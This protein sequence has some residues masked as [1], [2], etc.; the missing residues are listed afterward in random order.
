MKLI[1]KKNKCYLPSSFLLSRL[2]GNSTDI[3]SLCE[4]QSR[5]HWNPNLI[6]LFSNNA[7]CFLGLELCILLKLNEIINQRH[8]SSVFLFQYLYRASGMNTVTWKKCHFLQLCD[9]KSSHFVEIRGTSSSCVHPIF[10]KT[11]KLLLRFLYLHKKMELC[12][13]QG[14]VTPF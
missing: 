6:Y 11:Y 4:K 10:I 13:F 12:D 7:F 14:V 1:K 8:N 5:R 3:S 9:S 2:N